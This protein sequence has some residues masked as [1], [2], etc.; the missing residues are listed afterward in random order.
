MSKLTDP[1]VQEALALIFEL[2]SS[3]ELTFEDIEYY[4]SEM[5]GESSE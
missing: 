5:A 1:E 4:Y 3:G 2:I